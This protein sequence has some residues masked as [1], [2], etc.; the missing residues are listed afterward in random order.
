MGQGK[1][2]D[3][4]GGAKALYQSEDNGET[5]ECIED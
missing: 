3:Y 4:A 2:G 5:W 1:N